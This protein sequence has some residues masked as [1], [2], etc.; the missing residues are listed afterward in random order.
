RA[1]PSRYAG[2]SE[3]TVASRGAGAMRFEFSS[4]VQGLRAELER[5]MDRHVYPAEA[6]YREQLENAADRWA[7]PPILFEL[8]A[9]A[10]AAGLWNLFLPHGEHGAGLRNL[11][12]AP[13]AEIMGRVVWAA[14]VFNCNAPDTGN[15]EVLLHYGSEAQ[16]QRWL[17][18]LLN[19]E[20]RSAFAM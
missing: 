18:P 17:Q 13:L 11:E 6:L 1:R 15:M 9:R 10:K 20:I 12:Y 2:A 8:Q 19:G 3:R 4:L 7:T 14:E 5:F 16:R